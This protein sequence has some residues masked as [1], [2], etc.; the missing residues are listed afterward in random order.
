MRLEGISS[1]AAC[2]YGDLFSRFNESTDSKAR[3]ASIVHTR[4]VVRFLYIA[5]TSR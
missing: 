5:T 2:S 4:D 3:R 1:R